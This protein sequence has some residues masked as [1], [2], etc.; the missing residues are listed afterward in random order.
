MKSRIAS[1]AAASVHRAG[2]DERRDD[3]R[4]LKELFDMP[5]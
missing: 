3:R 4:F 2:S 5:R 1:T